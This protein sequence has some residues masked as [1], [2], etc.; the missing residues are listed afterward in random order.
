MTTCN[1]SYSQRTPYQQSIDP[2]HDIGCPAWVD[3][4]PDQFDNLP[5]FAVTADTRPGYEALCQAL[6]VTPNTDA[7]ITKNAY[8][9][10]YAEFDEEQWAAKTR[11]EHV[12]WQLDAERLDGI[13]AE[14]KA[15]RVPQPAT[16][17]GRYLVCRACGQG[18]YVGEH[19]FSTNPASGLCDDCQ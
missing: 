19:P 4:N 10:R 8:G 5:A 15:A 6:N 16:P 3:W 1:C 11:A 13:E 9:L 17:R 18:G 14:A 12:L 2:D 7:A